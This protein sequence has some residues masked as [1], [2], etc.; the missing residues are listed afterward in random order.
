[1][2]RA[3]C[4][5][6]I[7][8]VVLALGL[9]TALSACAPQPGPGPDG[10]DAP[11]VQGDEQ[12]DDDAQPDVDEGSAVP[13]EG[14]DPEQE[15]RIGGIALGFGGP[16]N[17]DI[18]QSDNGDGTLCQGVT[19]FWS[20]QVPDGV[21][22]TVDSI[23]TDPG[24]LQVESGTCGDY[25]VACADV[26]L[27]ATDAVQCGLLLRAP[28]DS[29]PETKV[30]I[31]GTIDCSDAATCAQMAGYQPDQGVEVVVDGQG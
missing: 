4:R 5:A 8:A 18:G 6:L 17:G 13:E 28:G 24:D 31:E 7:L 26:R 10:I 21:V 3:R 11:P 23:T 16:S 20:P 1:M 19:M 12:T 2:S 29:F 22:Y 25:P 9:G 15:T 30:L 27:S 14:Q